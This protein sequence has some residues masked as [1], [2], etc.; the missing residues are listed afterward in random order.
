[1]R[2]CQKT[3]NAPLAGMTDAATNTVAVIQ[4]AVRGYAVHGAAAESQGPQGGRPC[5]CPPSAFRKL[6]RHNDMIGALAAP[7]D[8]RAAAASGE[9]HDHRDPTATVASVA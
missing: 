8:C 7:P 4:G 1:M 3:K 9:H 6:G 5:P 2:F